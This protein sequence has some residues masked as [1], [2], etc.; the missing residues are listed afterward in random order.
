M[1]FVI[2]E[3]ILEKYIEEAGSTTAVVPDG[4]TKIGK[5]AFEHCEH[6]TSIFI[7]A[8]VEKLADRPPYSFP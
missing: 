5:N 4:V 6:L 7:P 8:S 3:N 2:K 1:S